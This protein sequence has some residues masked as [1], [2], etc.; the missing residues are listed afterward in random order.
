M[1]VPSIG[2]PQFN[3]YTNR[4]TYAPNM[5]NN[6]Q[7]NRVNQFANNSNN[8]SPYA[9]NPDPRFN[10]LP[11]PYAYPTPPQYVF[12]NNPV[13]KVNKTQRHLNFNPNK[14]PNDNNGQGNLNNT[15]AP[16]VNTWNTNNTGTNGFYSNSPTG[17]GL[18]NNWNPNSTSTG[19]QRY[20]TPYNTMTQSQ[21]QGMYPSYQAPIYH[22]PKP[23]PNNTPINGALSS[24]T[25][26]KQGRHSSGLTTNIGEIVGTRNVHQPPGQRFNQLA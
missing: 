11:K 24:P 2:H 4:S 14:G 19:N 10:A 1:A 23:R 7:N 20:S 8:T 21:S 16:N 18:N 3:P 13:P 12:M 17:Q 5:Q 25:E 26:G 9:N 6:G 22:P 15:G